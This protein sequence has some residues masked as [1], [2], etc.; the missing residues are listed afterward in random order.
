M[1][2]NTEERTVYLKD[3]LFSIAYRWRTLIAAALLF[4]LV[5]GA[6]VGFRTH[7]SNKQNTNIPAAPA[8]VQAQQAYDN[9]A[10]HLKEA[11]FMKLDFRSV[12]KASANLV[13]LLPESKVE[14]DTS[15]VNYASALIASYLSVFR[16]GSAAAVIGEETGVDGKYL[17]ELMYYTD[18]AASGMLTLSAVGTSAEE[19]QSLLDDMVAHLMTQKPQ[20][21][22]AIG[23]HDVRVTTTYVVEVMDENIL[24]QQTANKTKL[25]ELEASLKQANINNP[26]AKHASVLRQAVIFAVIGGVVGCFLVAMWAILVYLLGS[27]IYSARMLRNRTGIKILGRIPSGKPVNKIDRW[28]RKLEYRCVDAEAISAIAM[29]INCH[30]NGQLMIV[31][32]DDRICETVKQHLCDAGLANV[33]YGN[34]LRDGQAVQMLQNCESVILAEQCFVSKYTP[35]SML[36]EHITDSEKPFLGC[37]LLDG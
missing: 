3:M 11:P 36:C 10:T 12:Y 1:D 26:S 7:S 22:E 34:I 27:K 21:I 20:L 24:T 28:L 37:I 19:A 29:Q 13:V 32:Q 18:D 14:A 5:F 31:G 6:A 17:N 23:T 33:T 30:C 15:Q 16:S 4:A 35:V 25:A 8:V 9:Y 2:R